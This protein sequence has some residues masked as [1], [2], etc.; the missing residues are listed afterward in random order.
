[1]TTS[2]LLP[3]L[4][5]V[6][7]ALL[8]GSTT[9]R[10][11]QSDTT[12]PPDPA[13]QTRPNLVTDRSLERTGFQEASPYG[14]TYDLRT[15]FVM[16]YGV[17]AGVGDRLKRWIQAGYVPQIMTG[18]AW[19]GYQ[20]YLDGKFDGR[21]HWDEGQVNAAGHP[22][23]HGPTVPYMVPAVSFSDY[24]GTGIKRAIDAGAVAIHLE[25]PEFWADGGFSNA[26]KRE[27]QIYYNEPWQR[28]DSSCDAQYRAS[29]LK[30]YLYQR[31]LNRLCTAMK[32]YALATHGRSVRFY[33]PT[34]SLINYTQWR[35]VS[36]EASLIDLPGIDGYIAQIWTGTARTANVYRGVHKERTFE[37]AFLEYG[38]MQ[39]LVRGTDRRMWYLH[40]PVE[41]DPR[42]DWDDYRRNYLCTLVGSLLHPEI[43]YYEVSPWPNR[44]FNGRFP[45]GSK[46]PKPIPPDYA[47]ILGIVFN[48]LRDMKQNQ[49]RWPETT[50]GVGILL[51]DSGMFQRANPAFKEGT[52][53]DK[54]DPIRATTAEVHQWSSFYGL[55]LPPLKRGI[56][57]RPVQLDNVARFPG[58][59]DGYKVLL[60]SYE[61][62]KPLTPTLHLALAQWV[63][64]GGSLIY[65]GADTDPFNQVREWWNKPP[66]KYAAPSEHLFESLGLPRQP[67]EGQHKC[68][69]GLAFVVRKHPAFFS[70]SADTAKI[71][72][73]MVRQAVEA[74]GGKYIERNNL[75]LRRGPYVIAGCMDESVNTDPLKLTGRFVDLF[76]ATLP[77]RTEVVV[78]PGKQAFLLDLDAVV[79]Q[80]PLALASAARIETWKPGPNDL[81][82]TAT[83]IEGV[84]ASTRL[85]LPAGPKT[86][87]VAGKPCDNVMWDPATKTVLIRHAGNPAPQEVTIGW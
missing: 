25:E 69:K 40:D 70:R 48:Q 83:G 80:P 47:T 46:D 67:A 82:Y 31:A 8:T 39:E 79:G 38:I 41:D 33:V 18:V 1:M 6:S 12:P 76:D 43:W 72:T 3:K 62:M 11:E 78:Q 75:L 28:P 63:Q 74:A 30:Y 4:L 44:V 51:A 16:S 23:N 34:H 7:S 32:E 56:P 71:L 52:V 77:V 61:Y 24:L 19:G 86:V 36:P 22:I 17:D 14:P 54:R 57:I 66:R 20:D 60:L 5:V 35:I 15:D 42:H 87:T 21:K 64:A 13:A 49:V 81:H 9:L 50:E 10:A 37:T 2:Q 65:V 27:W 55:A 58:Y 26:F 45:A 73:D 84:Q 29:K 53:S 59:L 85:L 68:G